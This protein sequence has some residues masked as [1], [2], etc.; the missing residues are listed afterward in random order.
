MGGGETMAVIGIGTTSRV[1]V[2]EVLAV[3]AAARAKA[4]KAICALKEIC[5]LRDPAPAGKKGHAAAVLKAYSLPSAREGAGGFSPSLGERTFIAVLASLDR[6]AVN[7][8]LAEAAMA[9]GL[10][11]RLLSLEQ[12]QEV[13]PR[14]RTRSEKSIKQYGIP[15]VAEAA[16]LAAAGE[17]AELL[18]PR[19][20]GVNTTASVAIAP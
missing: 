14:C 20:C 16:A 4:N 13:A 8:V 18:V 17:W 19:F 3:L 15:S 6:P 10:Q 11:L 9:S 5:V 2:E 7:S 12:L 1:T